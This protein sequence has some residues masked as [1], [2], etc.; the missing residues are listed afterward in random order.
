M[1]QFFYST[2]IIFNLIKEKSMAINTYLLIYKKFQSL[3]SFLVLKQS[4]ISNH[5]LIM[6]IVQLRYMMLYTVTNRFL[7]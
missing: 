1:K 7:L 3:S 6:N 2:L 5:H 4:F